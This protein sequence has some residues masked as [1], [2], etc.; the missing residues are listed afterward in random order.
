MQAHGG[1]RHFLRENRFALAVAGA[2]LVILW[3]LV[4]GGQIFFGQA[5]SLAAWADNWDGSWYLSIV[6]HGYYAGSFNQQVNVAF[7]PLF[8]SLVWLVSKV[9]LMPPVWAGIL[10]SSASFAAALVVLHHFVRRFFNARTARWTLLL[11]AFNP[12][13][14][15]FGMMYTESLFLLLA[16]G[17]FWFI[18]TKQWWLA[19]FF[20]G[21]ATAARSVG[22]ALSVSVIGGLLLQAAKNGVTPGGAVP[23]NILAVFKVIGVLLLSISGLVFFSLYLWHQTGDFLAYRT[24]QTYWPGRGGLTNIGNELMYLWQHKTINME[25]ALMGMWYAAAVVAFVGLWLVIRMRQWIMALY[26]SIGLALPIL[27]GTA[28][29]MNRYMQV[30]FP[31]F[32]AYAAAGQKLP[33][34]LK[35]VFLLAGIAG[36]GLVTFLMVDPRDIFMA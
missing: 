29:S 5:V 35:V 15:Y 19:A 12:F 7:F 6:E 21:L 16:V 8:P 10:V 23:K 28:T 34:W 17:T 25:Y 13:S 11:V 3:A 1:A 18:Y 32:I 2:W 26:T 24:A 22:I 31:I 9:T 36:L 33:D 27:F 30:A 4:I 14:L 20:A